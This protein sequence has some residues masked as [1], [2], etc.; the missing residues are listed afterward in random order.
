MTIRRTLATAVAAAL[1]VAGVLAG[2]GPAAANPDTVIRPTAAYRVQNIS[3]ETPSAGAT[4][5]VAVDIP[6]LLRDG[7]DPGTTDD[8]DEVAAYTGAYRLQALSLNI[9]RVQLDTAYLGWGG[10][11]IEQSRV[12]PRN[13]GTRFQ[14][15]YTRSAGGN[16]WWGD[17]ASEPLYCL[18][19]LRVFFSARLDTGALVK[20]TLLSNPYIVPGN[21]TRPCR[22][23]P[24]Q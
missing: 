1:T 6:A 3:I 10:G 19:R 15:G 16:I 13:N 4:V 12:G 20:G 18:V 2:A 24:P 5:A 8:A 14:T 17:A 22:S 9:L 23:L 11:V 21:N 7:P